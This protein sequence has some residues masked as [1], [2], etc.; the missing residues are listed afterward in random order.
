MRQDT[1]LE[2]LLNLS[3]L[4]ARF[5]LENRG[6]GRAQE[7]IPALENS[8]ITEVVLKSSRSCEGQS[9][10]VCICDFPTRPTF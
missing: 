2:L 1:K 3:F 9:C 7:V 4:R 8:G 10:L 6:L 5:P